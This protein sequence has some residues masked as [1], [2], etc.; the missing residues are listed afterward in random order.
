MSGVPIG[1]EFWMTELP[2]RRVRGQF[3]AELG[4]KLE[5]RLE[6]GLPKAARQTRMGI[7]QL[8]T[9]RP[10]I[11]TSGPLPTFMPMGSTSAG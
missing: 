5:A 10:N 7:D 6:A 2:E 9:P 3:T 4:E 8:R 11:P 1:G